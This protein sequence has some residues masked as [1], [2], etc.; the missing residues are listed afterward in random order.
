MTTI[1][2]IRER[3]ARAQQHVIDL[4]DPAKPSVRWTMRIPAEPDRDSDLVIM[5]ALKDVEDL[6]A[7]GE[8]AQEALRRFH[9]AGRLGATPA[10]HEAFGASLAILERAIAPL[11]GTDGL[12]EHVTSSVVTKEE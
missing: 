1:D 8:A 9:A 10:D 7:V 3:N 4:C 12:P 11:L 2:R 6:A 5:A